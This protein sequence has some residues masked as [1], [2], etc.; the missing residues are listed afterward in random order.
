MLFEIGLPNRKL[1]SD[2]TL[3]GK[4]KSTHVALSENA[5]P[6]FFFFFFFLLFG[7]R[8]T[9]ILFLGA[10]LHYI[11]FKGRSDFHEF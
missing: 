9:L 4:G 1:T 11:A 10:N 5:L 7:S 8:I 2:V 3:H 6:F